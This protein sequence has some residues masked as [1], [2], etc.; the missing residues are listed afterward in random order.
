AGLAQYRHN[1][2]GDLAMWQYVA[3]GNYP[4]F[5][6]LLRDIIDWCGIE[7]VI[8]G[9]DGPNIE[10]LVPNKEYI[11]LIRE[12]PVKAPPGIA[13]TEADVEAILAGNAKRVL[14]L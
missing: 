9:S 6:R 14:G 4:R 12:L 7:A 10:A 1:L 8:F 5:C 2:F 11:R 13:F 3:A